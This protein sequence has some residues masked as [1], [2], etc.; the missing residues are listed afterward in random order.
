MPIPNKICIY[1]IDVWIIFNTSC[2]V[3]VQVSPCPG[4]NCSFVKGV[5]VESR[6]SMCCCNGVT[7]SDFLLSSAA[8]LATRCL[9]SSTNF[10]FVAQAYLAKTVSVT[11]N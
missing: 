9:G 1:F 2:L 4:C 11:V 6:E 3:L 10:C 7:A 5:C 8:L